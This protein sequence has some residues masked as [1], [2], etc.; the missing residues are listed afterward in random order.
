MKHTK[1]RRELKKE[2]IQNAEIT[3]DGLS[4]D[5]IATIL[6]ISKSEVKRIE[7]IALRKLQR[8]NEKVKELHRLIG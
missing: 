6:G 7:N 3:E 2:R 4:Y 8:P 1:G 5:E